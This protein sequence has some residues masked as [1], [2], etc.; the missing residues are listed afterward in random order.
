M[1]V[2]NSMMITNMLSNL[3]KNLNIMS[4]RQDELAT[5]KRVIHASDDPVAAA[6]ILKFKTDISD[7]AQYG[8]NTRDAQAWLDATESTVAEMGS[9][10]QR[11]RE[12]AVQASNGTNTADDTKKIKEEIDQLK[13]HM[14]SSANFN[15]AGRYIFSS[16]YTDRE[17][18]TPDGKYNIP[19]T[20]EDLSNKS[21]SIYEVSSKEK[22]PIGTHGLDLFGFIA[23]ESAFQDQMPDALGTGKAA[24]KGAIQAGFDLKAD[25][26]GDT[27]T[28]TVNGTLFTLDNTK[29]KGSSGV[30]LSAKDVL[31]VFNAAKETAPGT[32]TLSG[33]ANVYFDTSMNL[34]IRNKTI[35]TQDE[36]GNP[37]TLQLSNFSGM[38]NPVDITDP[39]NPAAM[40]ALTDLVNG[41]DAVNGTVVS[42]INFETAGVGDY[43][44]KQF[45]MTLNSVTKTITIPKDPA[46]TTDVLLQ[47]AVQ[48][49]IDAA[50]GAGKVT[51]G[52][53][54]GTPITFATTAGSGDPQ[55]PTIRIQPVKGTESQLI[56]DML[57][58][59]TALETA[60]PTA[61]SGMIDKVD[62]HLNQLLSVRADIG[63]RGSRLELITSRINE[64]TVTFT[65]LL[66]DSQDADMSEVIMYLKNAEN[67]YKAAL[68]V[69]GKIIQPSLVDFLR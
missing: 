52:I 56:K 25:Y 15:F 8:V 67:V 35:S 41:Q 44:G 20:A 50:F 46:I 68:G 48:T 37:A 5:G 51:V 18:L 11:V 65:R 28:V 17:L 47:S 55:T 54:E 26:S 42:S 7:M 6:K 66:S 12:L 13:N 43:L 36:L 3:N 10:L 45:V 57:D 4:R 16:H 60:D 59:S 32:K 21:V 62:G 39:D 58:F 23:E 30:P 34:V 63:A 64:N 69:G 38:S 24:Q 19:I 33:M 53:A 27:T 40:G 14:I 1:R 49:Q 9:V 22:M 29:L 2:T 31:D 61:L